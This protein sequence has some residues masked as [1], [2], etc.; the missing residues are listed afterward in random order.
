MLEEKNGKDLV[1]ISDFDG[2]ISIQDSNERLFIQHGTVE[3]RHIEFLYAI[4]KIGTR[5]GMARHFKHLTLSEKEYSQFIM[6]EISLDSTFKRFYE[7]TTKRGIPFM[8]VSGGFINGIQ[9]LLTREGITLDNVYANELIFS[10][11]AIEVDFLHHSNDCVCSTAG[12]GNCKL[13]HLEEMK[14]HGKTIIYIGD[15]LTDRCIAEKAD[16]VY[17]KGYLKQYCEKQMIPYMP[18]DSFEDIRCHLLRG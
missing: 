13:L 2:T 8:V 10:E 4:G 14:L 17:A 18:F 15:G 3:N 11:G 9:L 7:E 16:I 1:I 5:E 12:C 6:N